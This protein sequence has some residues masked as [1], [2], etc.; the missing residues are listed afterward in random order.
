MYD[1]VTSAT[2]TAYLTFCFTSNFIAKMNLKMLRNLMLIMYVK[3]NNRLTK[4]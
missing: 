2:F 3:M 4:I 1:Y